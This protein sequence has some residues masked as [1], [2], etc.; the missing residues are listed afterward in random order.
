MAILK[1][2][3][4]LATFFVMGVQV[5]KYPEIIRRM[6][7]R[8]QCLPHC[9]KGAMVLHGCL[10]TSNSYKQEGSENV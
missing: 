4:A 8:T 1:V 2:H 10:K 3:E 5:E 7:R 9:C 6:S